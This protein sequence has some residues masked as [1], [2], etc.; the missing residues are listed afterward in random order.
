MALLCHK[1]VSIA[2]LSFFS[3]LSLEVIV[4][5][6]PSEFQE[7]DCL[8]DLLLDFEV[9]DPLLQSPGTD[10]GSLIEFLHCL[11]KINHEFAFGASNDALKII[12]L[13]CL[14]KGVC[15]LFVGGKKV[16]PI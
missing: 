11:L 15:F 14:H 1:G 10:G 12:H 16:N 8:L 9:L 6:L 2:A 4:L 3:L 7:D 13:D 5:L